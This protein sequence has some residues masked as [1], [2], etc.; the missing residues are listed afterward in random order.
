MPPYIYQPVRY[1]RYRNRL[2]GV[3]ENV[4]NLNQMSQINQ[5]PTNQMPYNPMQQQ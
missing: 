4:N 2:G 5:I 3:Q 1:L